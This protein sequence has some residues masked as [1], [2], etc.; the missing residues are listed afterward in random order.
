MKNKHFSLFFKVNLLLTS[1]LFLLFLQY[2]SHYT[3]FEFILLS[4]SAISSATL[5]Y[6]IFYILLYIFSFTKKIILYIAMILFVITNIALIIDFFIFNLYKFHINAMVFNILLSPEALN[7]IQIGIVPILFTLLF[8]G[9]LIVLELFII[10]KLLKID[11]DLANT[12]N[13]Q[14]NKIVFIPLLLIVLGEKISYGI[15]SLTSQK[16][17]LAK[18]K[19]IPLYQPLTFN[20]IAFKY[21]GY[22]PK[23]QVINTINTKGTL[24]Y[25]LTPIVLKKVLNKINIIIIASDAVRYSMIN[26]INTPN[27]EKFKKDSIVL[28]N[29]HS[30]GNATRFGIFS[31]MYGL[32]STYWF[33]FLE[34][35]KGAVVFDVLKK[36]NYQFNIV[37]ST[38]TLWP[39][40]KKTCYVDIQDSIKDDFKGKPWELDQQSSEYFINKLDS[41]DGKRPLFSFLFMDSPHGYSYP[42]EFNKFHAN[43]ENINYMLATKGSNE[44]KKALARYKNAIA[45]NDHLF[46][47]IITKLKEKKL[48]DNSLI[49]FTS[50]HGQ[51]F[52]EYGYFGH[53]TAFSEAQT[54]IPLIIKL[55][56]TL[57]DKYHVED[58]TM[59]TSHIDIMPTILSIIGVT[60]PTTEY[61]NGYNIFDKNFK[62]DFVF[63][64]NWNNNAIITKDKKYIFSNL[65]N[66]MFQTEIRDN[67]YTKLTNQK[68]D[69]KKVLIIMKENGRFIK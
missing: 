13:K 69:A 18:Y 8:I 45:Y 50:D 65:P 41:Y 52:Y 51:E 61:S 56:K 24:K 64:A 35:Q 15:F 10:H 68:I 12:K 21:F 25:P 7:S 37:S 16:T 66:K 14:F 5:L 48:Y 27:I 40:F 6:I 31:L 3:L 1:V 46:S 19:V 38:S 32:N 59:L 28:Q 42:K 33:N 39:E 54:H 53:N 47:N 60:N 22:K 9:G 30:G 29:H 4:F 17:I 63:C 58:T 57:K 62:R 20:R 67:N 49:I 36:L 11:N 34:A 43:G 55:P 2:N 26:K 44:I 23:K